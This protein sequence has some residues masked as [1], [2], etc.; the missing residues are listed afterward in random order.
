MNKDQKQIEESGIR[1]KKM[2]FPN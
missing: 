1:G 2:T